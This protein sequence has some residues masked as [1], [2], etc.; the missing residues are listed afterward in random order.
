MLNDM[1]QKR[2]KKGKYVGYKPVFAGLASFENILSV[3]E[4]F[5]L[6]F[7]IK[8]MVEKRTTISKSHLPYMEQWIYQVLRPV[9]TN[10]KNYMV[11]ISV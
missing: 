7:H 4:I 8:E 10:K 5:T 9:H 1:S 11:T 3:F 6:S 2:I